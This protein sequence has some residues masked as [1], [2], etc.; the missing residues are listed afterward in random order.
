MNNSPILGKT[1]FATAFDGAPT[2]AKAPALNPR[3]YADSSVYDNFHNPPTPPNILDQYDLSILTYDQHKNS[4]KDPRAPEAYTRLLSTW[5]GSIPLQHFWA[6]EI[7]FNTQFLTRFDAWA[8][9]LA[10]N[11]RTDSS[12]SLEEFPWEKFNSN[13]IKN[14]T[15]KD[16]QQNNLDGGA[17]SMG[18]FF[19]RT[20]NIPGERIETSNASINQAG[21]MLFPRFISK[22]AALNNLQISFM[23]TNASFVDAVIRPWSIINSYSG[24][25]ARNPSDTLQPLKTT[26]T[27]TFYSK[28][29][30]TTYISRATTGKQIGI[31][32]ENTQTRI[33]PRKKFI[34]NNAMPVSVNAQEH[35]YVGESLQ[36]RAVD[37]LYTSY[38]IDMSDAIN[39]ISSDDVLIT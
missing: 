9:L 36:S 19:A 1:N 27:A 6:V 33:V 28:I 34:F 14:L 10:Q 15:V 20:V 29:S 7:D 35:S 11:T 2:G 23:E 18:C 32:T 21:G 26:V 8:S 37:F 31:A 22:R 4:Y 13:I 25:I 16:Y 38:K 3:Y 30:N 39:S 24:N 17:Y 5:A 12:Y